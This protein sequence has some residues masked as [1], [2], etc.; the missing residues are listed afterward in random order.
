[1]PILL[2]E[3]NKLNMDKG[4]SKYQT[5]KQQARTRPHNERRHMDKIA[6]FCRYPADSESCQKSLLQAWNEGMLAEHCIFQ[7]LRSNWHRC[8]Q[9]LLAGLTPR[10]LQHESDGHRIEGL[11]EACKQVILLGYPLEIRVI[12]DVFYEAY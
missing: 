8:R 11:G 3:N 12:A 5:T 2:S 4:G 7:G 9:L 6:E 10:P 1:M